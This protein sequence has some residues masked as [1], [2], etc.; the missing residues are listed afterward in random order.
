MKILSVFDCQKKTIE[1]VLYS[2]ISEYL[3]FYCYLGSDSEDVLLPA[4]PSEAS[5][6]G[7]CIYPAFV[8][9][10]TLPADVDRDILER[11]GLIG[12]PPT[13]SL[14]YLMFV[15]SLVLFCKY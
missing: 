1:N 8:L 7:V 11:Q 10:G 15:Y 13:A 12:S 5:C 3:K 9:T 2:K 14:E 4:L 6:R